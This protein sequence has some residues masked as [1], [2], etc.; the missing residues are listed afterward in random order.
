MSLTTKIAVL[1]LALS[2]AT[3]SQN[4]RTGP[5]ALGNAAMGAPVSAAAERPPSTSPFGF[6]YGMTREQ[7]ISKLGRSAVKKDSD[8]N[9]VV[10]TA[11]NPH[12][13]FESYVLAFSPQ[14]GLLKVV[15]LS[16]DIET[17]DD[18]SELRDKFSVFRSALAE[19]YG[20]PEKDFDFCK[21]NEVE[22]ESR[23][24]M[25]ELM[26]KNR[27]LDSYWTL[28]GGNNLPIHLSTIAIEAKALSLNKGY[29]S[30]GYEFEG[31]DEFVD[32]QNKKRN[33]P[34]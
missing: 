9:M 3:T 30:I 20:K 28:S 29:V 23:Y 10:S 5:G 22:C 27:V 25:M 16:K 12:P 17:S 13:D 31:W 11:P 33:S 21:G 2:I 26:E 34:F 8:V 18:G 6:E 32:D 4:P 15:A 7:V 1:V 14:K 19:K 24:Y